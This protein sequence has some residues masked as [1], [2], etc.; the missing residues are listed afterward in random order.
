MKLNKHIKSISLVFAIFILSGCASHPRK[1]KAKVPL[2]SLEKQYSN[3]V[4]I[5]EKYWSQLSDPFATR[6]YHE[7]L[8]VEL[9][10]IYTSALGQ[11]CRLLNIVELSSNNSRLACAAVNQSTV[12][13][14]WYLITSVVQETAAFNL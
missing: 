10:E 6:L 13:N 3:G 9:G 1:I 8:T 2:V 7:T 14:Q 11:S 12:S 5:S 4:A